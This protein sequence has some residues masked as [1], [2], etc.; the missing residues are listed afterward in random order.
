MNINKPSMLL[1]SIAA[2]LLLVCGGFFTMGG[3]VNT[4]STIPTGL[5]RK[6]DEPLTIGKIVVFCPPN[7]PEFQAARDRG[8]IK[9]GSC[10]DNFD[11][12][13]LKVAAKY[14]NKVTIN[15]SGVMVNDVLYP[16]SKPLAQD[17]EGRVIPKLKLD[18]YELKENE[19]LLMSDSNDDS[20]DGRYFGVIDVGQVDSVIRPFLQ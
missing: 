7:K 17:R 9:P 11:N 12:M 4:R 1:M 3:I 20:F 16:Q 14:K 18:N 10:P 8:A 13:M 15:D 6:V 5:Y 2:I 19:V